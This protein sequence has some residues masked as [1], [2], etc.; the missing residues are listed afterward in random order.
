MPIKNIIFDL[1]GVIIDLD[2]NRT[3]AA[4]RKLGAANINA[5]YT[6]SKQD[7]L[8]DQYEIGKISSEV[9]RAALQKKLSIRVNLKEFD[10]AWNAMLLDIPQK[11]LDFIKRLK[12]DYKIFLFSNTNEIHLKE[13]FNICQRQNGFNSFKDYFDKEYYSNIFGKRKP[14]PAAFSLILTENKLTASETLFVDDSMQHILGAEEAGL[15]T[16]HISKERSIFDVLIF[17]KEMNKETQ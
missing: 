11:R 7:D 12:N 10:D 16:M 1:G 13:V 9:F 15:H 3:F 14:D 8:F 4:F 5:I 2:Y 6:Q 17:I